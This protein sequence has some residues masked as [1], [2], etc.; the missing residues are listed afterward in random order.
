M[1]T[2]MGVNFHFS[3]RFAEKLSKKIKVKKIKN[4]LMILN[5]KIYGNNK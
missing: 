5:S 3:E 1:I 4:D 2:L